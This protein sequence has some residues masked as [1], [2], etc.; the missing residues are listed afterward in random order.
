MARLKVNG[1]SVAWQLP[2]LDVVVD[3]PP[4]GQ[5]ASLTTTRSAAT[6]GV[7]GVVPVRSFSLFFFWFGVR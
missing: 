2:A 4:L 3:V 1:E 7:V 5:R 6:L